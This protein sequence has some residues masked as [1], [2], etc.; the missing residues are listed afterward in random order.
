MSA[1][2]QQPPVNP[3]ASPEEPSTNGAQVDAAT[4]SNLN[5]NSTENSEAKKEKEVNL[6]ED[7]IGWVKQQN[8]AVMHKVNY[9]VLEWIHKLALEDT[10]NRAIPV[11]DH[12]FVTRGQFLEDLRDGFLLARVANKLFPGSIET[13]HT[14][15][16][17]KANKD[18]QNANLE[19]FLQ[20]AKDKAGIEQL[21]EVNNLQE[22]GKAGFEDVFNTLVNLGLV[23]QEKFGQVGLDISKIAEDSASAVESSFVQNILNQLKKTNPSSLR[24]SISSL[25]NFG[26][27]TQSSE[28]PNTNGEVDSQT[29]NG[30]AQA[31]TESQEKPK[32]D[33]QLQDN[34]EKP[35]EANSAQPVQASS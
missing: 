24:K 25:F 6:S 30:N 15:D 18:N 7:P 2:V 12:G 32:E 13:V 10:E 33:T 31:T 19:A 21:F 3:A 5:G 20:F 26:Q 16:A 22:K 29:A 9:H 11:R 23:A 1:E 28:Q 17:A 27:G 14:S 4:P 8:K 34:P 35:V